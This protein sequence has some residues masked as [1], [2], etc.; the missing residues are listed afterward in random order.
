MFVWLLYIIIL[1]IIIQCVVVGPL[2]QIR[3]RFG[4]LEIWELDY[5]A[6]KVPILCC[7]WVRLSAATTD[8]DEITFIDLNQI[9]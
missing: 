7:K 5:G 3:R 8:P 9:A 1:Q 4:L 2:F 6:L